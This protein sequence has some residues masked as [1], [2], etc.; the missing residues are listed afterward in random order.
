MNNYFL[1]KILYDMWHDN[2]YYYLL[3]T[4]INCVYI[5]DVLMAKCMCN[6]WWLAYVVS[7]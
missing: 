5:Y 1:V 4:I 2:Y 7:N 3:N 6:Y